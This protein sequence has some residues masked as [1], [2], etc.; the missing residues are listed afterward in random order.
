M[1]RAAW[2]SAAVTAAR[3]TGRL[4]AMLICALVVSMLVA[5]FPSHAGH[6]IAHPDTHAELTAY[7]PDQSDGVD[8]GA[9][10]DCSVHPGC[11]AVVLGDAAEVPVMHVSSAVSPERRDPLAGILVPPLPHP[12]NLS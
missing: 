8:P 11:H 10:V 4:R 6:E 5:A 2:I 12:P 3:A 9:D 1:T 7:S